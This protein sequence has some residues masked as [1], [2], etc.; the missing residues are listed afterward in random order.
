M[1]RFVRKLSES[2]NGSVAPT[3][4]LSI[5]A[6]VAAGGLA[7]DYARMATMDSELQDAADQAALAAASQLTGDAG[8]CA[9]AA[10][11]AAN[12]VTNLTLMANDALGPG[13]IVPNEGACDAVGQIRFYQDIGKTQAATSDATAKFVEVEVN[14]RTARFALTPV[15]QAFSSGPIRAIAF[16]TLGEAYCK[17]PPVMICNPQETATNLDFDFTGLNGVGM[18]LVSVGGGSGSWAP[19]NF[20][21]LDMPGLSN[22]ATGLRE[23]LGWGT[24]PT[25]C[26]AET[27]LDTKPGA[28]VDVTDSINTRFDIYDGTAC[29]TPGSC[30]ASMNSAKDLKRPANASG[31]NSCRIH[32]NGW[33]LPVGYY[34]SGSV[35]S[36]A[37]GPLPATVTPS[38]MGHPRDMCHSVDMTAAG[39]CTKTLPNGNLDWDPIGNGAWDRDA[40]FRTNY[41]WDNAEWQTYTK[42]GA[43][44]RRYDVYLWEMANRGKSVGGVTVLAQNPFGVTDST[45]VSQ[46]Q[47]VCSAAQ[48]YG[49]G[50]VP[51]LTTP[52]R[53][54]IT[55]AI[56]NCMQQSVNGNSTNVQTVGWLDAF[57]VEPSINRARTNRGD[58]YVEVVGATTTG[59]QIVSKKV[60]YLIE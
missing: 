30:P 8:A 26:I 53:R 32:N 5:F 41:G 4:G 46:S 1:L 45:L 42:L 54:L 10:A 47:A 17:V 15:V 18:R 60:P 39:A 20:G 16:S 44:P 28:T 19:G 3:V 49:S 40:Y 31:G 6:L 7:F 37:T 24:P 23:G 57:L 43:T 14:P 12:L 2:T 52:D 56:V 29:P 9:R 27:G 36:D 21:Y 51:D 11:A 38:A 59:V 35:P 13:I 34:G 25:D 48:G 22:G 58:V 50:Q 55:V 33:Q